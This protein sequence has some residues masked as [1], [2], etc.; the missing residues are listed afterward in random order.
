LNTDWPHDDSLTL[1]PIMLRYRTVVK[2]PKATG[3]SA[4][5]VNRMVWISC[6]IPWCRR[7]RGRTGLRTAV[8]PRIRMSE[9]A[10]R[11]PGMI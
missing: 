2:G 11:E 7:R 1:L 8:A 9:D 10:R 5:H 6:P 3:L 4:P